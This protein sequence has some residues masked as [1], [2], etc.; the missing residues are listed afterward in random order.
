MSKFRL[1]FSA[2][3]PEV[4]VSATRSRILVGH[5][6]NITCSISRTEPTDYT[7]EWT[8]TD[9]SG[10]ITTLAETGETLVLTAITEDGFGT[11]TCNVTNSA[12]L[13][14]SANITIEEGGESMVYSRHTL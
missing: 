2:V 14:G 5:S 12:G 13:S 11:Y 4:S 9:T 3:P 10:T 6:T 7:I 8:L 1:Y